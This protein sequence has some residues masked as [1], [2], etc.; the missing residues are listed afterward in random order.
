MRALP[1]VF[2]L[3]VADCSH[4]PRLELPLAAGKNPIIRLAHEQAVVCGAPV[5]IKRID[6][7]RSQLLV[8]DP[9]ANANATNCLK[10]W[11]VKNAALGVED[12][13]MGNEGYRQ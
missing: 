1:L 8:I 9:M 10:S 7:G 6:R 11:V 2:M 13:F 3:A 12:G 4:A 5:R